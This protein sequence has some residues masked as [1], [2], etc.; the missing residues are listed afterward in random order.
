[1][2]KQAVQLYVKLEQNLQEMKLEMAR[3]EYPVC[4]K[5]KETELSRKW[6]E[7]SGQDIPDRDKNIGDTKRNHRTGK[8]I[9]KGLQK[10]SRRG[11]GA[12]GR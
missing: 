6:K 4:E 7:V 12:S 1:M 10:R 8:P 5:G 3:T 11:T 9:G 2:K